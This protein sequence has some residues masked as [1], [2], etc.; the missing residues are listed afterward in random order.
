VHLFKSLVFAE[1]GA[2]IA[3]AV[4]PKITTGVGVD[5]CSW[6][7]YYLRTDAVT[8]DHSP[9]AMSREDVYLNDDQYPL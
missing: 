6:T 2:L 7:T 1:I 4:Q 5:V 3:Q 8:D 9:C